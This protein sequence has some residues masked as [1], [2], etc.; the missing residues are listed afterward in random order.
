[1]REIVA[2]EPK[3]KAVFPA[4]DSYNWHIY[5]SEMVLS[6]WHAPKLCGTA[7]YSD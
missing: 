2:E 3:H 6:Q 1:M 5:V 4:G 7:L